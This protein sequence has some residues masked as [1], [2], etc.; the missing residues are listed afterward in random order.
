VEELIDELRRDA[1]AEKQP[2]PSAA[3]KPR[4][5]WEKDGDWWKR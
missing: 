1:A 2:A 3:P 4:E 5:A